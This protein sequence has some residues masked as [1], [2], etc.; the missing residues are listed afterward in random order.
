MAEFRIREV[1]PALTKAFE[2]LAADVKEATFTNA[3]IKAVP[4]YFDMKKRIEECNKEIAELSNKLRKLEYKENT[5]NYNFERHIDNLK[6]QLV[7][8][9][10][11][12]KNFGTKKAPASRKK[13]AGPVKKSQPKKS[14]KKKA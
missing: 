14:P 10:R 9:Q 11:D 7:T 6:D 8:A 3:I 1:S 12:A 4:R 2:L 5:L 13:A